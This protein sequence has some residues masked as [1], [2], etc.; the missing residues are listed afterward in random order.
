M[1]QIHGLI[2]SLKKMIIIII[3]NFDSSQVT[4]IISVKYSLQFENNEQWR[5]VKSI[6]KPFSD[7]HSVKNVDRD[8]LCWFLKCGSLV[9]IISTKKFLGEL[10][11]RRTR[12]RVVSYIVIYMVISCEITKQNRCNCAFKCT[13]WG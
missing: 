10:Y 13:F 5:N 3:W 2:D 1:N 7:R 8:K 4:C 9:V 6:P 12:V 11:H